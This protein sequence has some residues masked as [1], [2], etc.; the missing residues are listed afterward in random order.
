LP[1][2]PTGWDGRDG[3]LAGAIGSSVREGDARI[4]EDPYAVSL[5][6]AL[7][8]CSPRSS[9]PRST[10]ST[11]AGG[12]VGIG[13]PPSGFQ[14]GEGGRSCRCAASLGGGHR[15]PVVEVRPWLVRAGGSLLRRAELALRMAGGLIL[16]GPRRRF[17]PG[18]GGRPPTG[19]ELAPRLGPRMAAGALAD[20]RRAPRVTRLEC[21]RSGGLRL[22]I[23]R[24]EPVTRRS[25]SET[26]T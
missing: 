23:H 10:R 5:G 7:A 13:S 15:R 14:A 22:R 6:R 4:G 12:V 26:D 20:T 21:G 18:S 16:D 2:P 8:P 1:T 19:S 3:A 11:S 9:R 17:H 24:V 25:S